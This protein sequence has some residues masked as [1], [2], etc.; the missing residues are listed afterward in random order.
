MPR[1]A[2]DF[3]SGASDQFRH[4]GGARVPLSAGGAGLPVER[5]ARLE[6]LRRLPEHDRDQLVVLEREGG[7]I[8]VLLDAV[9]P[10]LQRA[11]VVADALRA[12]PDAPLAEDLAEGVLAL[13]RRL[14]V[15]NA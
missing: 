12:E 1:G 14:E 7:G 15:D 9:H 13:V 3:K 8:P 6:S 2:P 4:P 10:P 11:A 5:R